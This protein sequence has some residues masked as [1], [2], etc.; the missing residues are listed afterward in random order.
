MDKT[1]VP[2]SRKVP[3]IHDVEVDGTGDVTFKI[4]GGY[5]GDI[6]TR[7]FNA[8]ELISIVIFAKR[9]YDAYQHYAKSGYEDPNVYW[10]FFK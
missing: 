9:H 3:D 10:M 7:I 8:D 4:E 5:H 6:E 1:Q 2:F